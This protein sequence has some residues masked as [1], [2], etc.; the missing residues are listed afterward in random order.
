MSVLRWRLAF[1]AVSCLLLW[2]LDASLFATRFLSS[3]FPRAAAH[4]W[5]EKWM[6]LALRQQQQQQG[7]EEPPPVYTPEPG[8]GEVVEKKS[9]T[10]VAT[11]VA[12]P[13]EE[14]R[15]RR[16]RSVVEPI[17]EESGDAEAEKPQEKESG[18][19]SIVKQQS[20]NYKSTFLF[21]LSLCLVFAN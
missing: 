21:S 12:T 5:W 16:R 13:F 19:R 2:F 20:K 11:G 6:A 8:K 17:A 7:V 3:S 4:E 9:P 14:T 15:M 18:Y 1:C 10:T